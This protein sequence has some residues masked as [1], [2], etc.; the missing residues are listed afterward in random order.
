MKIINNKED[1]IQ[2]LNRISNRINSEKNIK[3]NLIVE[4][5]LQEVKNQFLSHE[6]YRTHRFPLSFNI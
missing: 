1:A 2:E 3:I 4:E 5:I 6:P